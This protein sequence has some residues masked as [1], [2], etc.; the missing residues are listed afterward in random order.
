MSHE[1]RTPLYGALGTVEL[2]SF[3]ALDAQQRQYVERI[4]TAAQ[5][6]MQL[7]SDILDISKIEAGQLQLA[8]ME[9][10][11]RELVQSCTGAYSAMAQRKGLLL[12]SIISTNVPLLV[13]G[14]RSD[15][16]KS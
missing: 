5:S 8:S 14:T 7:I 15:F 13:W 4:E 11:P 12:F 2:L 9:F 6:L 10:N 3:T 16:G 1:I